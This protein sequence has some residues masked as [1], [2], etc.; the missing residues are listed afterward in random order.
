M[1]V[2]CESVCFQLNPPP[3]FQYIIQTSSR[4]YNKNVKLYSFEQINR[5]LAFSV[6]YCFVFLFVCLFGVKALF[7]KYFRFAAANIPINVIVEIILPVLFTI[8]HRSLKSLSPWFVLTSMLLFA[9]L[10]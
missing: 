4:S 9:T 10:D 8:L 5:F 1:H 7:E 3:P 2:N 6:V